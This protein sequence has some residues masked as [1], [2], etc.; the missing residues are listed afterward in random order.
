MK[1]CQNKSTNARLFRFPKVNCRFTAELHDISRKQRIAW[2]RSVKFKN[3]NVL[4][5][6]IKNCRICESHF[7]SGKWLN[8][9]PVFSKALHFILSHQK[10]KFLGEPT[11]CLN[12]TSNYW[13]PSINLSPNDVEDSPMAT[14]IIIK[15]LFHLVSWRK[16]N[17]FV[18]WFVFWD[19]YYSIFI[20]PSI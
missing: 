17:R 11:H 5:D 19:R 7:K 2:F 6:Y 16:R 15:L 8:T 10:W 1:Y 20:H 4:I 9:A 18:V 12:T 13:I 14:T 3:T